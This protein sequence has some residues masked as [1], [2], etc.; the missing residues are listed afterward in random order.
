MDLWKWARVTHK[1]KPHITDSL[2]FGW[3]VKWMADG[4]KSIRMAFRFT[5]AINSQWIFSLLSFARLRVSSS[6]I[7]SFINRANTGDDVVC[8]R[9]PTPV[10]SLIS[11]IRWLKPR[12]DKK[13]NNRP[14]HWIDDDDTA[15]THSHFNRNEW[16][17]ESNSINTWWV[18]REG[19]RSPNPNPFRRMMEKQWERRKK[20][21]EAK[22]SQ[23]N[24]VVLVRGIAGT[25]FRDAINGWPASG[26]PVHSYWK[27][28]RWHDKIQME[29]VAKGVW[30]HRNYDLVRLT[31]R[32]IRRNMRNEN[33]GC[34]KRQIIAQLGD[35][36]CRPRKPLPM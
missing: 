20:I 29:M 14:T 17:S 35:G 24:C 22:I 23:Q 11:S 33:N 3:R 28:K 34:L 9:F 21:H 7:L 30:W 8:T 27:S 31:K 36:G 10:H 32:M 18:C 2:R 15:N 13:Y 1:H 16:W 26:A 19:V 12:C 5:F 25:L 6:L 4:K